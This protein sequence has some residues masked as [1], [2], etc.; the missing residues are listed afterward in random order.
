MGI[1]QIKNM[2]K[3]ENKKGFLGIFPYWADLMILCLFVTGFVWLQWWALPRQPAF[4]LFIISLEVVVFI[5]SFFQ[6]SWGLFLIILVIPG[7]T[8][9]S[10]TVFNKINPKVI[11]GVFGPAALFPTLA[12]VFGV[13]LRTI[14]KK[15]SLQ[16][17][18]LRDFLILFMGL[19]FL[20]ALV[21]LWRYASFCP[22]T[23]WEITEHIINIDRMTSDCA[24]RNV[25][26]MLVNYLTGPLLFLSIC[27]AS[28]IKIRNGLWK[29][30][31]LKFIFLPF[32]LG[33]LAPI[34]VGYIQKSNIWFGANKFYIWPWMN[35]MNATFFDPNALG[36]YILIAIPMILSGLALVYSISRKWAIPALLLSAAYLYFLLIFMAHSGSRMSLVGT[37]LFV[38]IVIS[39][40]LLFKIYKLKEKFSPVKF[41][42]LSAIIIFLY[43]AAS[44]AIVYSAPKI[45]NKIKNQ[46]FLSKTAL[47][48]RLVKMDIK[49]LGDLYKNIKKDRGVHARIAVK[50]IK[51]LPL[52]GVGLGAFIAEL[53]NYRKITKELVYVP[54]T[55]CNF[56]LQIGSEQGLITLAIILLVF[57]LWY[58]KWWRTARATDARM[59]W[60]FIGGSF[61]SI[62]V[63]FLFGTHT[64][65]HEIQCLFWLFLAQ[66]FI[67]NPEN[68]KT[69]LEA[70]YLW[71]IIA[72]VCVIYFSVAATK[73]SIEK[74]KKKYGWID[75]I[76]FFS[77]EKWPD[78]KMPR[79]RYSKK[80]SSE[81]ID[82]NG[83]VFE[84]KWCA[85][86]PDIK[87]NPV[88]IKF[89]LGNLTTNIVAADNNWHSLKL[90]LA[91]SNIYKK[92][93][94]SIKI[95][96]TW[97]ATSLGANNDRRR[98]GLLLSPILWKKSNGLYNK[99]KWRRDGG[100]M[101]EK[102]YSWTGKSAS[103]LFNP[104]GKFIKIP[105]LVSHPD[106]CSNSV[107]VKISAE[108][109][110]LAELI[111]T[112]N[113][114][115]EEILFAKNLSDNKKTILNFEV[116]RTMLPENF[117]I[118]DTRKLGVAV[119]T[120]VALKDYGFYNAEKWNNKFNYKW[121]GK[122]A[123]WAANPMS[124]NCVDI[125]YMIAHPDITNNPVKITFYA[126][127]NKIITENVNNP[128]WRKTKLLLNSNLWY[129]IEAEVNR[130]WRPSEFGLNDSRVLGFAVKFE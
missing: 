109:E 63:I 126:N 15:E 30:W 3:N 22:F 90:K 88:K 27:Q 81:L 113:S 44:C 101:S 48:Q 37:V 124:N 112:N 38:F 93:L 49:S 9:S 129:N 41:K 71:L 87:E 26:W 47:V 96:R 55:A 116:N 72:V 120:P 82:C 73:L 98:L 13:W 52:T 39:F 68:L 86:H 31:L 106:A 5:L 130:T 28:W 80:E 32:I 62:L 102:E 36:S 69:K 77:W 51:T 46:S 17:N 111:F 100:F 121:A 58:Y 23:G 122:K 105:L 33:S 125:F 76:Q 42:Y 91:A 12:F 29:K 119:G 78:P 34:T 74:E 20:S 35:R 57:V 75:N 117:G 104:K 70:K 59:Y 114:W 8:T 24:R 128:N 45:I 95:D 99:E 67:A 21:T 40:L 25:I 7:I 123:G 18:I 83:I 85:L 10:L 56:Y 16:P 1:T 60:I 66:P 65:A 61:A 118:Q 4:M 94:Y 103:I 89:Q 79:V 43:L 54:D 110:I 107:K 11:I 97:K 64:S 127:G 84:Q 19:T 53:P 50:M 92:I 108:K 14:V 2:K 115:R 6:P